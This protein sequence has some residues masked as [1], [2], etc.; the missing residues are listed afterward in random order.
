MRNPVRPLRNSAAKVIGV[1]L[2]RVQFATAT[3]SLRIQSRA[4][5]AAKVS[6]KPEFQPD[7][8]AAFA[9]SM[10]QNFHQMFQH[11]YQA[12][13]PFSPFRGAP[14]TPN[15][16]TIFDS[17]ASPIN[18]NGNDLQSQTSVAMTPPRPREPT[19]PL[20]TPLLRSNA[21]SFE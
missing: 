11:M 12:P 14:M 3:P 8:S 10:F 17:N 19:T 20:W 18:N 7:N 15:F 5:D 9:I 6:P 13:P 21:L 4:P 16:N 1:A 2:S